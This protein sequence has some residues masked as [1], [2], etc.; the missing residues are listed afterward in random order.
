MVNILA[1]FIRKTESGGIDSLK[2]VSVLPFIF[3]ASQ[4]RRDASAP[5][6]NEPRHKKPP[7]SD[8]RSLQ[9]APAQHLC[10]PGSACGGF[11]SGSRRGGEIQRY[12]AME[13][14]HQ[15]G[16]EPGS[17]ALPARREIQPMAER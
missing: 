10:I 11:H 12:S 13:P 17:N 14:V 4:H 6:L 3:K 5:L 16:S 1:D 2:I 8:C 15:Y 9:R 7:K